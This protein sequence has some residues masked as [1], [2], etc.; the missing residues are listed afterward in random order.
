MSNYISNC[1]I[2]DNIT[3]KKQNI[4]QPISAYIYVAKGENVEESISTQCEKM[5]GSKIKFFT[6]TSISD[7]NLFFK[8]DTI[9]LKGEK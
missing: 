8:A 4:S 9:K 3:F 2:V 7:R 1:Y 6:Y 5:G